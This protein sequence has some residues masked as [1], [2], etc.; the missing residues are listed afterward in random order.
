MKGKN[1]CAVIWVKTTRNIF[2][3]V[4]WIKVLIC[5]IRTI[6]QK[7]LDFCLNDI[8]TSKSEDLCVLKATPF[9]VLQQFSTVITCESRKNFVWVYENHLL[10]HCYMFIYPSNTLISKYKGY[11]SIVYIRT[12]IQGTSKN[13]FPLVLSQTTVYF[14]L[15]ILC[16]VLCKI[17][18][19]ALRRVCLVLNVYN[20]IK[21]KKFKEIF[22]HSYEH[23]WLDR[24]IIMYM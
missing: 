1:Q 2:F 21:K 5:T 3:V 24:P 10:L 18:W 20:Y 22:F 12:F 11:W 14:F 8:W 17:K 13:T 23:L 15:S 4:L 6:P 9:W 7:S 19:N 16:G